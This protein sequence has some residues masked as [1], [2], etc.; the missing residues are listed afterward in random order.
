MKRIFIAV[1]SESLKGLTALIH[2]LCEENLFNQFDDRYYAIDSM[3]SEVAAFNALGERLHTDRVKGF[4]LNIFPADETVRQ[5]FQPGWAYQGVPAGG[6]GG[7]RTISGKAV[8]LL[9]TIWN[10][11]DFNLGVALGTEDQIIIA[12]SA[13]GGTSGGLFMNVCDFIDLQIRR[14]RDADDG[15]K[16]VQVL[17]FLL[18]PEPVAAQGNYPIAINMISLFKD[19]Q[20][21]SWRRRLESEREGFKVPVLAQ[22]EQGYFP[23]F[24]RTTSDAH[25]LTERGVQ[26]SSLPVGRVYVVPTPLGGLAYTTAILA[27]QLFAAAYL[28]I[29]Q[30]HARWVDRYIAGQ[31][32]PAQCIDAEDRCFAGFNMFAMKSGRMVSLK[33]W[34]YKRLLGVL[35]GEDGKSGFLYGE[36]SDSESTFTGNIKKVFLDAQMPERDDQFAGVALE[37]CLALKTVVDRE[38]DAITNPKALSDFQS[39]FK[40]LLTAVSMAVPA[41]EVVP[42]KELI[43]LLASDAYSNWNAEINLA[44]IKKGYEAF[45]SEVALQANNISVY[46]EQMEEALSHAIR[47]AKERVKNR[48]VRNW[49]F[50]LSQEGA[51]FSEIAQ[52]FDRKFK[53]LLRNYVYACRCA[54]S[55]FMSVSAFSQGLSE[56]EKTCE[57]LSRTFE[58][59]CGGLKKGS[60]NPY[61]VEGRLVEPLEKLPS[62]EEAKLAFHPFKVVLLAAYRACVS[63]AV[64][65]ARTLKDFQA[66]GGTADEL[67]SVDLTSDALLEA[68]EERVINKYLEV[69]SRLPPGGSPLAKATVADFAEVKYRCKTHAKEFRF[70]S[71]VAGDFY[72]YHFVVKQGGIPTGF[73]MTNS[74]VTGDQGGLGFTT[75]P[76]TGDGAGAFL[77]VNHGIGAVDQNYWKDETTQASRVFAGS[78]VPAEQ[79]PVQGLWIGTL[80]IDFTVHDILT[81]LYASTPHVKLAWIKAEL[82]A[83]SARS[84][85][86]LSEMV[87]FGLVIEALEAKVKEAWK[88]HGAAN[89]TVL[90]NDALVRITFE[91]NGATFELG[92]G[93]LADFGFIDNPDQTCQ[94]ERISVE[95]VGRILKWIRAVDT[96]SFSSFFPTAQLTSVR[97]C[98]TNIFDD[99]RLSITPNE[100]QEMDAIKNAISN[101]VHIVGL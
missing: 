56:F 77:S 72:Y 94:M 17:G 91:K 92:R 21:A 16:N 29:D 40:S 1:G 67:A 69:A 88:P 43:V 25:L 14:K 79:L 50:G 80:G 85:I 59:K 64:L 15:F 24:T 45:Y 27:E 20:T 7:D 65:N 68:V 66:A 13:F 74:D 5:S 6:V 54:R 49:A 47:Y 86:A 53:A 23:L 93:T 84:A 31:L 48:V 8:E 95:W 4:T 39:E 51:V 63:D 98:E 75:M 60:Q 37:S 32:G 18:M 90:L 12:G 89:E 36:A 81:R 78:H 96:A 33:N 38:C 34:F 76:N 62:T 44:L 42:P 28:R 52:L 2:R 83:M 22:R 30:G 9:K 101:T 97:K 99:M 73:H 100:I 41:Y 46:A 3:A 57:T 82:A 55:P 87:R 35:R 70:S 71:P 58:G 26:G 19:L 61:V 10:H 11:P